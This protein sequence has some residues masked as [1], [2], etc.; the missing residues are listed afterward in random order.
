MA[1][2]LEVREILLL[3]QSRAP[4]DRERLMLAL[5]DLCEG[6]ASGGTVVQVE[7]VVPTVMKT[8]EQKIQLARDVVG[9]ADA[10]GKKARRV[11]A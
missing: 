6:A 2:T 10:V 9:A 3:A 11:G 8:L 7:R 1:D 5:V 4:E